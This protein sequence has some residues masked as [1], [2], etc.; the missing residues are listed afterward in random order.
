M[1]QTILTAQGLERPTL[2]EL[3]EQLG[4]SLSTVVGPISRNPTSN[5][6]QLIGVF[7]EAFGVSYEVAEE[8]FNSRFIGRASG[9]ALDSLGEWIG[10]PRRGKTNTT[11]PVILYG[12]NG[13]P[14][15]AGSQAGYNNNL[16]TVDVDTTISLANTTDV[17]YRVVISGAGTLGLRVQGQ[18][19]Q[20]TKT[21]AP[22]AAAEIAALIA[23]AGKADNNSYTATSSGSDI[24]ITSPNLSAGIVVS[25]MSA[26]MQLIRLGTPASVTAVN[27]GPIVVPKGALN[28]AITAIGGWTGITNPVDA[29]TGADRESDTDYRQRLNAANGSLNGLA[30]PS[31]IKRVVS[32]VAGVTSVTVIQNKTLTTASDGQPGKSFK[33]VVAG[34][35]VQDIAQAILQAGGAGIETFGSISETVADEDNDPQVI[36]FSRMILQAFSLE[37][38]VS[39]RYSE[40][41]LSPGVETLIE[42]AMRAFFADM[43]MGEDI[44]VQRLYGPI[45]EAT[46]GIGKVDIVVKNSAGTV[47]TGDI[48]SVPGDT[49]ATLDTVKVTVS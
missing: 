7:A 3:L 49:K 19:Q 14:V 2:A 37:I 46:S 33:V 5:I 15:P 47:Q 34:G 36:R 29:A 38:T 9:V 20:S 43:A 32:G 6:G 27:S 48:I 11:S 45:Y 42:S 24:R 30:T 28:N 21:T 12:T 40:E 10:V 39:K 26:N 23:A 41:V 17:T 25:P 13:T 16:F 4:D 22:E 44:V 35:Q 8:L 18:N 31:A 1:A